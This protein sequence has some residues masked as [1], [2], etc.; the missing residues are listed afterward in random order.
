MGFGIRRSRK[1]SARLP[2]SNKPIKK[3]PSGQI[4]GFTTGSR[5]A[6]DFRDLSLRIL[7]HA[8]RAIPVTDF[9]RAASKMILDFSGCDSVELRLKEGDSYF[10]CKAKRRVKQSFLYEFIPPAQKDEGVSSS[11][12]QKDSALERLCDDILNRRFDSPLPFLTKKGSFWTGNTRIPLNFD[13]KA[14][15]REGAR[16]VSIGG[17]YRSLA[18]MPLFVGNET[19]GLLQL[20]SRR[21]GY[22]TENEIELYEDL[23]QNL[24]IALVNQRVH[25]AS[26]ERVKELTCL[27]GIA[28]AAEPPEISLEEILQRIVGLL[29]QAWQYPEIAFGRII[30]DGVSYSTPGFQD[31]RQKQSAIITVKGKKR[32]VV[33][34]VYAEKKP[35]LDEGPFLKEERSLIDAVARQVALLI[36]RREAE[37]DRSNLQ[38]QLRHADRLATIGQLAAGVAHEL[39]EP[40]GNI[41]GFAQLAQKCQGL[42][43]Q[44]EK[45]I[46]QIVSA[47]LHA[48]EVIKKL[49]LTARQMPPRKTHVNLNQV[50]EDGLYLLEARCAKGGIELERSLSSDLPEI[51][52][53]AAQLNQ[54]L[55]NLVVNSVQAMP[56]GGRLTVK[57]LVREGHILLIVE[58]T[59]I[60]MSEEVIK[61]IFI[62]FFTTKDVDQGTGLG[63]AVVQG[64]VTSHGGSIK[65]ESKVGRG[66]RFEVQLPVTESKG[67]KESGQDGTFS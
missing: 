34:V 41:L 40:L 2:R 39:N 50:V 51:T 37:E 16:S 35:K 25:A 13:P 28:K 23:A 57:T 17:H 67:A 27:Y 56:E 60:G 29:P 52:A 32:G 42:P 4:D 54:V 62:P 7:H 38:S 46:E 58:D 49:L 59:G 61:H 6:Q 65:V 47:S 53:D 15:D 22:F 44:A 24:G 43:K 48:R 63:L 31:S 5:P 11:G 36:E 64:I 21:R 14:N 9:L 19:I 3:R 55:V 8:N 1:L 20:Q 30:L 12:S 18:L 66:T 45:D 33:E 10:H 26:N